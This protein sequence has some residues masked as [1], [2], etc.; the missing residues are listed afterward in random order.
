MIPLPTGT[1]P[2]KQFAEVLVMKIA[3]PVCGNRVSTVFDTA[4]ELLM[5]ETRTGVAPEQSRAF[6]RE[7]TLIDRTARIRELGVQVLICGALSGAVSRMLEAAGVRVI[8][9][10]RGT[11]DE[12]FDAFCNGKLKGSHFFLPGC[13]PCTVD[14]QT[15]RRPSRRPGSNHQKL[16]Q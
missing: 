3:I 16:F 6:W 12:V 9:F 10:I 8:P 1:E 13:A 7:D 15:H 2:V 5:I 14:K 11:V 4:D